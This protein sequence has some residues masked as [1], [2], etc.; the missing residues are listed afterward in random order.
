MGV[1]PMVMTP[2]QFNTFWRAEITKWG[3]AVKASGASAN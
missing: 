1:L 2:D 3:Q